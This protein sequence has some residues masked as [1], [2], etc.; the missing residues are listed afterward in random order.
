VTDN[1][2]RA[3]HELDGSSW[4]DMPED[5]QERMR[6]QVEF[7]LPD[8]SPP[9]QCFAGMRMMKWS[10]GNISMPGYNWERPPR[11]WE[12]RWFKAIAVMLAGASIVWL[13]LRLRF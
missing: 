2:V 10:R 3:F 8:R 11:L 12:R 7:A 4:D 13:Q 1:I 9:P 6:S 5:M